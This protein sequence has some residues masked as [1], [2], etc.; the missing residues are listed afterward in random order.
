MNQRNQRIF[1]SYCVI[2][3]VKPIISIAYAVFGNPHDS[4]DRR[5][6]PTLSRRQS[7]WRL[8]GKQAVSEPFPP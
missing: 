1:K 4:Q 6:R 3:N 7:E 8:Q 2:K 5:E